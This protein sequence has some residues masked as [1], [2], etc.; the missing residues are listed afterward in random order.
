MS[1]EDPQAPTP[2]EVLSTPPPVRDLE[3]VLAER[4]S[5]GGLPTS[6]AALLAIVL[7]AVGFLGG[8][9]V[10]RQTASNDQTSASGGFPGG[11]PTPSGGMPG[12]AGGAGAGAGGTA[13]TVT[14]VDGDTLYVKTANGD[15]VKVVVGS[16][17]KIQVSQEG[18]LADISK[19]STVFVRGTTSNG[20]LN[21]TSITEGDLGLGAFGGPAPGGSGGSSSGG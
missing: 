5:R 8:L 13:G 10:G 11:S 9:F 17:T 18:S 16:D 19:G 12:G 15:T 1:T 4:P 2:D 3:S 20:E 21:A 7:L 6:T 14:R